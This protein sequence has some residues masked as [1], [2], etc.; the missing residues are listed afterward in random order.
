MLL[1][2]EYKNRFNDYLNKET[3]LL[4]LDIEDLKYQIDLIKE[5]MK[6]RIVTSSASKTVNN[7]IND[8]YFVQACI[9]DLNFLDLKIE[10]LERELQRRNQG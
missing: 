5:G 3:Y 6:V 1:T 2:R 9:D 10:E 8:I 7:I 4:K